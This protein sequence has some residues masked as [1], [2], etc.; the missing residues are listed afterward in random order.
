MRFLLVHGAW[1]GAWCRERVVAALE[2]RGQRAH[3]ID[4]PSHETDP[5]PAATVTLEDYVRAIG[6]ALRARSGR[7]VL[8]SHSIGG[9][10]KPA[11]SRPPRGLKLG[12]NRQHL[13]R[14]PWSTISSAL[15]HARQRLPASPVRSRARQ[16]CA[17]PINRSSPRRSFLPPS[18]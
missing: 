8:V 4:L 6:V 12:I 16:G 17:R 14:T 9:I 11:P 13:R 10:P 15:L 7:S 2:E 1:H 5:T 3:A 18:R